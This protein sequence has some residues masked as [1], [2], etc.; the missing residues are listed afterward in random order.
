MDTS[1]VNLLQVIA[2]AGAPLLF[3]ALAISL[4]W[5]SVAHRV[6]F[7]ALAV[8]CFWGLSGII[9]PVALGLLNPTALGPA[10]YPSAEFNVLAATAMLAAL[11]GFPLLWRLRNVLRSA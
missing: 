5:R 8:L 2:L 6:L 1:H 4:A 3:A 7:S 9:Y 10:T 11:V